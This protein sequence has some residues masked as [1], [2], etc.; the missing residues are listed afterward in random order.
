MPKI[1]E[2]TQEE[3]R[4][5]FN[6][7]EDTGVLVWASIEG[8]PNKRSG[9]EAGWINS[10]GYRKVEYKGKEYSVAQLI[11]MYMSGPI[12]HGLEVDH[13]DQDRLNNKWDNLR[14]VTRRDNTQNRAVSKGNVDRVSNKGYR[15]RIW[16]D[17]KTVHLGCYPTPKQAHNAYLFAASLT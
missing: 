2:L 3:V 7:N 4:R 17:R 13:I 16:W 6:Y 8:S 5:A 15:A 14:L 9:K 12:S 11:Y 1:N 10:S